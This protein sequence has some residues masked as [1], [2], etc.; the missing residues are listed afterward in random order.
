V[1]QTLRL[2]SERGPF[3][4]IHALACPLCHQ[5]ISVGNH[6]KPISVNCGWSMP[7]G[8]GV[9]G[10]RTLKTHERLCIRN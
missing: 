10:I 1:H 7:R 5:D 9:P 2:L 8:T 3:S 6:P 4:G